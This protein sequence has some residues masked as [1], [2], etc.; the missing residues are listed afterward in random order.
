MRPG[1]IVDKKVASTSDEEGYFIMA[2]ANHSGK[3]YLRTSDLV[4]PLRKDEAAN[5]L[6]EMGLLDEEA[7]RLL[8]QA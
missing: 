5:V 3:P 1:S 2:P 4:N 8:A 6:R 7:V